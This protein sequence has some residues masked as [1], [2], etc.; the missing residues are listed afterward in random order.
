MDHAVT[1]HQLRSRTLLGV[2]A[3]YRVI[4]VN[5]RHALVEVVDVPGLD[6][7]MRFS[8]DVN[9][10]SEMAVVDI[11]AEVNSGLTELLTPQWSE[12]RAA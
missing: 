5:A 7:G 11:R 12:V 9:A 2:E 1:A 8:F 6:P 10:V 3:T 4:D